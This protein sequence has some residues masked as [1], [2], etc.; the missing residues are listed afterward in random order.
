MGVPQGS[1]YSLQVLALPSS[2]CG[3]SAA[4]PHAKA[5]LTSIILER[6][7]ALSVKSA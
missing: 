3:L 1:G 5:N 7:S 4:I 2:G 6:K